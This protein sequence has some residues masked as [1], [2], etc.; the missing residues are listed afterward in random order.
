[1]QNLLLLFYSDQM[2]L[3]QT[4]PDLRKWRNKTCDPKSI[5]NTKNTLIWRTELH[6]SK[7]TGYRY[8]NKIVPMCLQQRTNSAKHKTATET[9]A[10]LST[11]S[12]SVRHAAAAEQEMKESVYQTAFIGR[13]DLQAGQCA[14]RCWLVP[15][16]DWRRRSLIP[17]R[18][19]TCNHSR[20][21]CQP[22]Q[23]LRRPP[24]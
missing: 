18:P 17:H 9:Q 24:T 5:L 21:Y 11:V 3:S 10:W 22:L 6:R 20:T 14:E 7:S 13:Q 23:Q 4:V 16:N 8:G 12:E 2:L 19:Q 1:M 15:W